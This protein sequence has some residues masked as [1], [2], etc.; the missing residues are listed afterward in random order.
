MVDFLFR[1]VWVCCCFS[2]ENFVWGG[3]LVRV[4]WC[5]G[6]WSLCW[7]RW[8]FILVGFIVGFIRSCVFVSWSGCG[9]LCFWCYWFLYGWWWWW[10]VLVDW[11]IFWL[12]RGCR[13]LVL[14]CVG[15]V[16]VVCWWWGWFWCFWVVCLC[17]LL[18]G[19]GVVCGEFC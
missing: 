6:W 16:V 10:L 8:W 11:W 3:R 5:L 12:Y 14:D 4:S 15:F 1:L 9:R 7:F 2:L 18:I 13:W 17:F 19:F